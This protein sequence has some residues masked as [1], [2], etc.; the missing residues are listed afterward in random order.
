MIEREFKLAVEA[1][2]VL[3]DLTDAVPGLIV[4]PKVTLQLDAVYYDTPS[5][6]LARGE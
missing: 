4:G 5:L 3:P 2:I 6:A 1:G